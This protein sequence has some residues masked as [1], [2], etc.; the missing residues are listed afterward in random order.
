MAITTT[1]STITRMNLPE[2]KITLTA[3]NHSG[4]LPKD[5]WPNLTASNQTILCYI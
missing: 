2:E 4:V 3:L 1:G 5:G